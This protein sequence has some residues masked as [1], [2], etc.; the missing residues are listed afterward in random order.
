MQR[1]QP[2][3]PGAASLPLGQVRHTPVCEYRPAGQP[4]Q[5]LWS[6]AAWVAT[7]HVWQLIPSSAT[8]VAGHGAQWVESF[9]KAQLW[10]RLHGRL[11]QSAI[12]E[13]IRRTEAFCDGPAEHP[14]LS[15][16]GSD[17]DRQLWA[18]VAYEEL[19]GPITCSH[20]RQE[21]GAGHIGK[22]WSIQKNDRQ[23]VLLSEGEVVHREADS[24]LQ[25][26][27][28]PLQTRSVARHVADLVARLCK[29]LGD[30]VAEITKRRVSPYRLLSNWQEVTDTAAALTRRAPPWTAAFPVKLVSEM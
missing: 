30:T 21:E 26:Q 18:T 5:A 11:S 6:A 13:S 9:M 12:G 20:I 16:I 7:G 17:L 8:R 15:A 19:G 4:S 3:C 27:A 22:T 25:E 24:V 10:P 28:V 1:R 23:S 29:A 14:E 2:C